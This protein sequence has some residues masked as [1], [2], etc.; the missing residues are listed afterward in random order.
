MKKLLT[1]LFLFC[2]YISFAQ[3]VVNRSGPANTVQDARWMAQYNLFVPRYADTTAANLSSGVDSCGAIIF[4]YNTNGLW[5]RL[6]S[7]KRWSQLSSATSIN[8]YN[9]DGTISDAVRT[10]TLSASTDLTFV[11]GGIDQLFLRDYVTGVAS[12]DNS[13]RILFYNDSI[14]IEGLERSAS[15]RNKYITFD[16]A[17]GR[18]YYGDGG[19]SSVQQGL[20]DVI[21]YDNILTKNDTI[22]SNSFYMYFDSTDIIVHERYETDG[23]DY[24]TQLFGNKIEFTHSGAYTP[25][26]GSAGLN[27]MIFRWFQNDTLLHV[28]GVHNGPLDKHFYLAHLTSVIDG[29][30][31][32][33]NRLMTV[34]ADAGTFMSWYLN[35]TND[36]AQVL[37]G[38]GVTWAAVTGY[39]NYRFVNGET[40]LFSDTARF[41]DIVRMDGLPSGAGATVVM[42]DASGYLSETT[43]DTSLISNFSVKVRALFS[44][45]NGTTYNS[46]I[47]RYDL[48]GTMSSNIVFQ[49][50]S[51]RKVRIIDSTSGT[52]ST[53]EVVGKVDNILGSPLFVTNIGRPATVPSYNPIATFQASSM[54]AGDISMIRIGKEF[55]SNQMAMIGFEFQSS[56]ATSNTF[57]R[58][59]GG[60]NQ[61]RWYQNGKARF[62]NYGDGTFT[63]TL[64][65]LAGWDADGNFIEVDTNGFTPSIDTFVI[66]IDKTYD[67]IAWARH[68]DTLKLKSLRV[69]FNGSTVTPTRT[70]S[71]ISW[72]IVGAANNIYT[73]DGSIGEN[74]VV[75]IASASSVRWDLQDA[76]AF[77]MIRTGSDT[78]LYGSGADFRLPSLTSGAST[79]SVLVYTAS[80]G[81]VHFRNA[82]AFAGSGCTTC[83]DSVF[84]LAD[85]S[86]FYLQRQNGNKDTVQ[87]GLPDNI[88]DSVYK[89]AGID[90]IYIRQLD[91][92]IYAI[93]DSI[94]GGGSSAW[95]A[96][97][98][99]TTSLSLT[100]DDA[101]TNTFTNNS[102]TETFW[103]FTNNSLTTGNVLLAES[104]TITTGTLLSLT[105]TS[106]AANAFSLA[107]ISS[108]G[109]NANASRTANGLTVS[110]TNTGTTST[111]NG[112]VVT[113]SGASTNN[114]INSTG[115]IT[116]ASG[117]LNLPTSSTNGLSF[118]GTVRMYD[119]G[120]KIRLS[121]SAG[122]MQFFTS[123]SNFTF[124]LYN[125]A[126]D[127]YISITPLS[128]TGT[129]IETLGSATNLKFQKTAANTIAIGD[130]AATAKLH[131][132]AGT[133][134]LAP[135]KLTSGT[136]LTTAAAGAFEYNG[137][138]FFLSP[139]TTRL[140]VVLTDNS[141]PSNGQIPI[142]NGVDYTNAAITSPNGTITVTNGAGSIGLDI[143]NYAL[144]TYTPTLTNTTNI[145]ASTAN[146]TYYQ[147]IGDAI[148][149]WGTVTVDATLA[150]TISEMGMSL[151]V[152]SGVGQDYEIG[153]TASFEDNTSVQIIG[154]VA[155]GRAKWR[156]TPQSATNNKYSFH[157]T[158]KYNAP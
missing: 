127:S 87:I 28:M 155:N 78:T 52:Q 139:S 48:G 21:T 134:T 72:N 41:S 2:F 120:S 152:A 83:Y 137:T 93:E 30:G 158:Y 116:I 147:R 86:G 156:F 151:P 122:T 154:D 146:T 141:I 150:L 33:A 142:G 104:S 119:D 70:D 31:I 58:D 145:A 3:P 9:S 105:S 114:A 77:F 37:I 82:S 153:G 118:G 38:Y 128:G 16:T 40:S 88:V 103:R 50:T 112:I 59:I 66:Q 68:V 15:A 102:N 106:T 51:N 60:T 12:P 73:A 108:S 7:P 117:N 115:T 130:F 36:N 138:S 39:Q 89:T 19:G 85:S 42:T 135:F 20:Q 1:I 27:S 113:A 101:E 34:E 92:T 79:D 13:N 111:N 64:T 32:P 23:G 53:L 49:G 55:N 126:G 84:L 26:S 18:M 75:A 80:T 46:G 132:A 54:I 148:H 10:V 29:P 144:T 47:G 45:G 63:G 131:I 76:T 96:L 95:S 35:P 22:K 11:R 100:F 121:P 140:R 81:R 124:Q 129:T 69:Q 143:A 17:T 109:A 91:G 5:V 90:S 65:K 149:V 61:A 94:G 14:D 62:D 56:A 97:T 99:P 107:S 4:T 44:S 25:G 6:C 71:T 110:V 24:Y 136:N 8:I 98:D 157:F 74:R 125:S 43:M 57:I 133:T 67:S 123:G